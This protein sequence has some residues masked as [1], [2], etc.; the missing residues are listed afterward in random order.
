MTNANELPTYRTLMLGTE[1]SGKTVF[2][3]S[4]Y[5]YL[6]IQHAET[7]FYL[8]GEPIQHR[9]LINE[10]QVIRD[11]SLPWPTSTT[12]VEE[13]NFTCQVRQREQNFAVFNFIYYSITAQH[14][15]GTRKS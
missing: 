1:G 4:M 9:R 10:F 2:I 12:I 3:A 7:G 8:A 15:H 6:S 11:S 5:Q 14:L 13:W